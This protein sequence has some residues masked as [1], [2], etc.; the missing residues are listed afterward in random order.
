MDSTIQFHDLE[1]V[2][3]DGLPPSIA[4]EGEQPAPGDP[5][6][7]A[8]CYAALDSV[9]H[10]DAVWGTATFTRSERWGLIFRN[11]FYE[12]RRKFRSITRVTAWKTS[13]GGLG[14]DLD[15]K[16]VGPEA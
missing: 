6:L 11:S 3:P 4:D 1:R 7:A 16:W 9:V 2:A 8:A 13:D 15:A 14:I 10:E 12:P 5:A